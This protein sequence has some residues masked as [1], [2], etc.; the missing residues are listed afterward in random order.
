V[1][2]QTKVGLAVMCL[3]L[4][5]AAGGAGLLKF[6]HGLATP[7]GPA[8]FPLTMGWLLIGCGAFGVLLGAGIAFWVDR[9]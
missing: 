3:S 7:H 6:A 8:E 1:E 2:K 9:S 4:S 5:T